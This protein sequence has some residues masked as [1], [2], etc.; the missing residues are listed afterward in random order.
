MCDDAAAIVKAFA[1]QQA[2]RV[3]GAKYCTSSAGGKEMLGNGLLR[4]RDMQSRQGEVVLG[5]LVWLR[6]EYPSTLEVLA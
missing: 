6:V 2:L 3:L 5:V 4:S 1:D